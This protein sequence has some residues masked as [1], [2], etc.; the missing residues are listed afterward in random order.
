MVMYHQVVEGKGGV[1]TGKAI[2]DFVDLGVAKREA[3]RLNSEAGETRYTVV[4]HYPNADPSFQ[5]RR[6]D[7]LPRV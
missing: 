3:F 6:K 2:R 1:Q 7:D 5:V 4:D